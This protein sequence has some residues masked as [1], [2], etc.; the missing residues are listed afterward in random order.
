MISK[1][2]ELNFLHVPS[3]VVA[4]VII[5]IGYFKCMDNYLPTCHFVNLKPD[6]SFEIKVFIS[7]L[8]FNK[9]FISTFYLILFLS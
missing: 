4:K 1:A 8:N 2:L 9:P 3:Y 5:K 7:C 6:N